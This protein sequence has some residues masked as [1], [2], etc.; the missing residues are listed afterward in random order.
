MSCTGIG[1]RIAREYRERPRQLRSLIQSLRLL[2]AEIEFSVTPLPEALQRVARR[3]TRPVNGLLERVA[4]SL[5]ESD[6]TVV[7]AFAAAVE[8]TRSKVALLPADFDA[9]QDFGST[10]GTSDRVHQTKH[11]AAALAE[12]ERLEQDAREAQ[13]RNERLWQYLGILGGLLLLILLY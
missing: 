11:F 4:V 6:S 10:L 8:Q 7:E 3:S 13:N 2:Q 1:F 9:L 5:A 12:F